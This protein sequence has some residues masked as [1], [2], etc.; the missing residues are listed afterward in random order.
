MK[1]ARILIVVVLAVIFIGGCS[2]GIAAKV[3]ATS[4]PTTAPTAA[5]TAIPT[6][7]EIENSLGSDLL[8]K[9]ISKLKPKLKDPNSFQLLNLKA[10]DAYYVEE[11]G[12]FANRVSFTYT[13]TNSY[14][15]RIQNTCYA[16]GWGYYDIKTDKI[17]YD[18]L[19]VNGTE[20]EMMFLV[21]AKDWRELIEKSMHNKD[22]K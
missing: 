14:G 2:G 13:A 4:E 15:G 17:K 8:N 22:G 1:K 19:Y 12:F 18:E 5:P 3:L 7:R 21:S 10:A 11:D 20:A 16:T 6:V 9:A